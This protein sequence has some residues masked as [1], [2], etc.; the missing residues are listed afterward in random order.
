M[1]SRDSRNILGILRHMRHDT[2]CLDQENGVV[3]EWVTG[4][5]II[6]GKRTPLCFFQG[7]C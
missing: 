5:P 1:N 4:V 3:G 6:F 7:V 2:Q